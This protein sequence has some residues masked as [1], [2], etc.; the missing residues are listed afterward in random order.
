MVNKSFV[1]LKCLLNSNYVWALGEAMAPV[2]QHWIHHFLWCHHSTN[3]QFMRLGHHFVMMMIIS[4]WRST[5][6]ISD[7]HATLDYNF[8]QLHDIR[9]S[10]LSD[11]LQTLLHVFIACT[12]DYCNSLQLDYLS[13]I[14]R[15]CGQFTT[16]LI[17]CLA[18]SSTT[19]LLWNQIYLLPIAM[20]FFPDCS[21][22][23]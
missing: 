8:K 19:M 22:S 13:V 17:N 1:F 2:P 18:N 15:D 4:T 9:H 16:P 6:Q 3:I 12:L 20:Y 23:L 11:V 10:L 14:P 21:P 5:L 7:V